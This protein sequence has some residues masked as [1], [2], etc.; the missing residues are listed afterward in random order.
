VTRYAIRHADS[1][2]LALIREDNHVVAIWLQ[3][4]DQASTWRSMREA[5]LAALDP[6]QRALL[7]LDSWT[8]VT[9][10]PQNV[11]RVSSV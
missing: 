7:P 6:A 1:R 8:V 3:T 9:L 4:V 10:P 2:W 5:T 11:R